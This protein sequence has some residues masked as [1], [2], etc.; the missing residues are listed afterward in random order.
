MSS[1]KHFRF[2]PFQAR[3]PASLLWL[4]GLISP[5]LA[6]A[7]FSPFGGNDAL[8]ASGTI[9]GSDYAYGANDRLYDTNATLAQGQSASVGVTRQDPLKSVGGAGMSARAGFGYLESRTSA[10]ASWVPARNPPADGSEGGGSWTTDTGYT[11]SPGGLRMTFFSDTVTVNAAGHVGQAGVAHASLQLSTQL[12]LSLPNVDIG[13]AAFDKASIGVLAEIATGRVDSWG[14]SGLS[15]ATSH[16][17]A[18]GGVGMGYSGAFNGFSVSNGNNAVYS[19]V[20]PATYRILVDI[21][22][23]IGQAFS[24]NARL[25]GSAHAESGQPN[26][27]PGDLAHTFTRYAFGQSNVSLTWG[28][29]DSISLNPLSSVPALE[30]ASTSDVALTDFS[31]T[32]GSGADYRLAI[33]AVPEPASWLLMLGGVA[34]LTARARKISVRGGAPNNRR[35]GLDR[36]HASTC[37]SRIC[38]GSAPLPNTVS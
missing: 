16:L 8:G 3:R 13:A 12:S 11:G 31:V 29:I 22:I 9:L 1:A 37:S 14:E 21:P 32:S 15:Q 27:P 33:T 2:L 35:Q 10:S 38:S 23:V 26:L 28:G 36:T 4:L 5:G 19:G 24:L 34:A 17:V 7:N 20:L 25:E 6:L 30:A 18:Q